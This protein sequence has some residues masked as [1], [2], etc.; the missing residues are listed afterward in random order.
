MNQILSFAELY[1][2][3]NREI[4]TSNLEKHD[5]KA[6]FIASL[7]TIV[8]NNKEKLTKLKEKIT[9]ISKLFS[10][11]IADKIISCIDKYM[12]QLSQY[13][14]FFNNDV[15]EFTQEEIKK[16][17]EFAEIIDR[18]DD[19]LSEVMNASYTDFSNLIS[20]NLKSGKIKSDELTQLISVLSL[21]ENQK[22]AMLHALTDYK[23]AEQQTVKDEKGKESSE[24]AETDSGQ[25]NDTSEQADIAEQENDVEY[26]AG[27]DYHNSVQD[28]K[29]Q[30][31]ISELDMLIDELRSKSNLSFVEAIRLYS[32][33]EEREELRKSSY[34][35]KSVASNVREKQMSSLDSKISDYN[36]QIKS[37]LQKQEQMKSQLFKYVSNMK[38][39]RLQGK[40]TSLQ[41]KF[42]T[43]K[44]AQAAAAIHAYDTQNRMISFKA[45][46]ATAKKVITDTAKMI[47]NEFNNIKADF[48]KFVSK[49]NK[50]QDMRNG[51]VVITRPPSTISL[52]LP[53]Q[54]MSSSIVAI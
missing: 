1:I 27:N 51:N 20:E 14:G 7:D 6:D 24:S 28:K 25:S 42:G 37:E 45:K 22:D 53:E 15:D 29:K 21:N 31:R 54:Q 17:N 35:K 47:K 26:V 3:Y 38:I 46:L 36:E 40:M 12:E 16:I 50:V 44:S 18:L 4:D 11:D 5:K 52:R 8:S 23:N 10:S 19:E 48:S 13:Q 41:E 30:D 49:K 33:V 2:I 39:G 43:V 32:L 9:Q 34:T